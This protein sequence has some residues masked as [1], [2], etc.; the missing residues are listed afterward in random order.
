MFH[1][2]LAYKIVRINMDPQKPYLGP[3]GT[4]TSHREN[5]KGGVKLRI[6][7]LSLQKDHVI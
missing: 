7:H 1:F 5:K 6:T 2:L 3:E 4:N